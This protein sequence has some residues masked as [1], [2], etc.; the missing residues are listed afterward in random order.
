MPLK[1]E[2]KGAPPLPLPLSSSSAA[3]AAGVSLLGGGRGGSGRRDGR[4]SLRMSLSDG[5]LVG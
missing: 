4:H 3:A 2:I 1:I 5:R